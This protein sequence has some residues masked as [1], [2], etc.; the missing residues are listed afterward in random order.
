VSIKL[1]KSE[2]AEQL[3]NLAEGTLNTT[4]NDSV[5][6][7][8]LGSGQGAKFPSSGDFRVTVENEI[9]LCTSRS[10]DTLT[11]TRGQEGTTNVAHTA[12]VAV[13]HTLTKAGLDAYLGQVSQPLDS[14]LSALAGLTSAADKLPYFTGSGTAAVTDFS[15]FARTVV[16]D[17]SAKAM[18]ATLSVPYVYARN[19]AP[20]EA[21]STA[22]E[23]TIF[24]QSITGGDMGT[25]RML[26]LTMFGDYLFNANTAHTL[27]LRYYFGG[28]IYMAAANSGTAVLS[29]TRK[30][31]R[32]VYEVTN[33]GSA[34][35]QMLSG[36]L[37]THASDT[38]APTAGIGHG[39]H[40]LEGG[41]AAR[42]EPSGGLLAVS[43]LGNKDTSSAQTLA[44]TVQ[45]SNASASNSWRP[46]YAVLELV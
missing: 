25:D 30:P 10:T 43:T 17:A 39:V 11:V 13:A 34:S 18:A 3:S 4:M 12:G 22:S 36:S 28:T 41:V 20:T 15:T 24:T 45:W 35:S 32:I 2:M 23:T 37:L 26:R 19:T 38:G 46:R 7:L 5:T 42:N 8:V 1:V 40:F 27:T 16:D 6:S 44:V 33:L 14:E 31:W 9:M 21:E 29:A